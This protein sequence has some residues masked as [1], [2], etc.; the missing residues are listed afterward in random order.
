MVSPLLKRVIYPGLSRWGWLRSRSAQTPAVLTYH[1]VSPAGYRTIDPFLDGNL[2]TASAFRRHLQFLKTYYQVVSPEDFAR[3]CRN[4]ISLPSNAVLLTCDDGLRNNVTEMLPL[5]LEFG[6]RCLFFVTG[7][8]TAET[9]ATLWHEELC[10]MLLAAKEAFDLQLRKLGIAI[11]VTPQQRHM[12]WHE[13]IDQLSGLD[14]NARRS[15]LDEIRCQI[16]L[17]ADWD[18]KYRKDSIN[19]A[20]FL[21]MNAIELRRLHESG[22]TIGAHTISH[23][24]L[25]RMPTDLAANEL[26]KNRKDLQDALGVDIWAFAYPFGDASSVSVR[27]AR[28][29]RQSG[30]VC[31][32]LNVEESFIQDPGMFLLP[33]IHVTGDMNCAELDARICGIHA[34]LQRLLA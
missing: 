19:A 34:S 26:R 8:S 6:M 21:T 14:N 4:E 27:E 7:A 1:G 3:Y 18:A 33:R 22:M 28:M 32:F 16:G 13:L 20:R 15:V 31:G 5:L 9:G 12:C 24:K 2:I 23:P 29:A 17:S 10:L 11:R 30:F 25:S